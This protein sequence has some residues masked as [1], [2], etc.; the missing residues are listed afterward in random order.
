D[1]LW[2]TVARHREHLRS[3]G[4]LERRRVARVAEELRRV[5]TA[6]V[7]QD[8]EALA[9]AGAF[10]AAVAAITSGDLDPYR[11]AEQLLG[12]GWGA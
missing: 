7:L 4:G 8:V 12:E 3:T 9:S 1:E 6:R 2:E 10:E 11:A 5:L